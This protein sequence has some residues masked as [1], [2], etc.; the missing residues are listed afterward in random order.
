VEGHVTKDNF[1]TVLPFKVYDMIWYDIIMMNTIIISPM[2]SS[3][4]EPL[5]RP[6][7][8]QHVNVNA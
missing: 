2:C 5:S 8:N 4:S 7:Q 6:V 1:E 3:G